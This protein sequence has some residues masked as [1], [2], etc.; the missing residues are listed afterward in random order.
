MWTKITPEKALVLM[1]GR[2]SRSIALHVLTD[3]LD[4]AP[5]D[6]AE[7]DAWSLALSAEGCMDKGQIAYLREGSSLA[8]PALQSAIDTWLGTHG[9]AQCKRKGP[10]TPLACTG[11]SFHH[12]ADSY[13]DEVFCVLWLSDDTPWDLY[14]PYIQTRVPLRY[15]TVI[16]FDSAQPHGVV[17]HGAT[18]FDFD[19]EN[20]AYQTG[21]FL[22]QDLVVDRRLRAA[23]GLQTYSRRGKQGFVLLNE[24]DCRDELD[25]ETAVWSQIRCR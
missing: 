21:V 10:A 16:L 18:A 9:L 3:Q 17:P 1:P 4:L 20:L 6:D 19:E 14:F 11:A 2:G 24:Q 5:L 12:D 15:G 7:N 13:A 25:P 22:S 8:T 23:L